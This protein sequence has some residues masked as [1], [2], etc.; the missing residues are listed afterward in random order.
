MNTC[1]LIAN[2]STCKVLLTIGLVVSLAP[3]AHGMPVVGSSNSLD[4]GEDF[5]IPMTPEA[6]GMLGTSFGLG[7]TVGFSRDWV[8]LTAADNTSEG[9]VWF[10]T[11]F[12]LSGELSPELPIIDSTVDMPVSLFLQDIDF[13]P[14]E[15]LR[16]QLVFR[17]WLEMAIVDEAGQ[18]VEGSQLLTIDESNYMSFRQ[19]LD[20]GN[21]P[22]IPTDDTPGSYEVSLMS[23]FGGY[24]QPWEDYIDLLNEVQVLNLK[25]TLHAE[26]AYYG[27]RR[28][29]VLN[30]PEN[31]DGSAIV[32]GVAPEP[33]TAMVVLMGAAALVAGKGRRSWP[34]KH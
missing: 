19:D 15:S 23:M 2:R 29:R 21:A 5:Y 32:Y 10:T 27:S 14:D 33:T 28:V 8:V 11:A 7:K 31:M 1:A 16:G 12:D 26:A 24:G 13:L 18:M 22:V 4:F 17:E 25:L 20:A 6:S 30:T 9:S 3:V 34:L